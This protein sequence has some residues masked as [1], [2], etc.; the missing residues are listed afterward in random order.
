LALRVACVTLS[1]ACARV[2]QVAELEWSDAAALAALPRAHLLLAADVAYGMDADSARTHTRACARTHG[3]CVPPLTHARLTHAAPAGGPRAAAAAEALAAALA[4]LAA[5]HAVILLAQLV[6]AR[7]APLTAC[8]LSLRAPSSHPH[9]RA[10]LRFPAAPAARGGA[11][12]R[13]A[14]GALF[15]RADRNARWRNDDVDDDNERGE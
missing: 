7:G 13:R 8:L 15:H 1:F 4:A 10:R 11:A 14:G 6:R 12:L 2:P 5:P 3:S 9:T